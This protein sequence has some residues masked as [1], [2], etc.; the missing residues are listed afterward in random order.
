MEK[1]KEKK[2]VVITGSKVAKVASILGLISCMVLIVTGVIKGTEI[3]WILIMS[4]AIGCGTA[5]VL[6]KEKEKK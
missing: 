5:L 4:V 3:D 1:K 2:V 6:T